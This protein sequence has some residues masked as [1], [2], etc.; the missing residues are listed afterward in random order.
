MVFS[1]S[2][3]DA[4]ELWLERN[5]FVSFELVPITP[6]YDVDLVQPLQTTLFVLFDKSDGN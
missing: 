5:Y 1:F 6:K 4:P 2:F 3:N